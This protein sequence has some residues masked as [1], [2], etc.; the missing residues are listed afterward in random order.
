MILLKA[1]LA[2]FPVAIIALLLYFVLT[3]AGTALVGG[4][5]G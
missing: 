4:L 2:A 5:G 1:G 3:I